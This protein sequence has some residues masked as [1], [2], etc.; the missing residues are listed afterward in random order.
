MLFFYLRDYLSKEKHQLKENNIRINFIGRRD[1]LNKSLLREIE[2][3]ERITKDNTDF[4][5]NIA[6]DYGGRWDIVNAAKMLSKEVLKGDVNL[7]NIDEKNFQK[8]LS[9]ADLPEPDL[10][11][12]TSG[13]LRIS[14]FL[15]W[16]SAYSEFY[17][18][19]CLWPDFDRR[20]FK[21]A[22]EEYSRRERRFGSIKKQNLTKR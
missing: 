21:K 22:I 5:L 10:L 7:D 3:T 1:R 15:L 6:L 8:Y 12:R 19:S 14:N 18:P 2:E 4:I 16:Q 13:E 17:F 11:I 20:E 9:L